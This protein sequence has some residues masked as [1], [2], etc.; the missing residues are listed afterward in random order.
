MDKFIDSYK[1]VYDTVKSARNKN[2][3]ELEK[4]G[5]L[6]SE[7]DQKIIQTFEYRSRKYAEHQLAPK[8]KD[9]HFSLNFQD[10]HDQFNR[11]DRLQFNKFLLE[12]ICENHLN[13]SGLSKKKGLLGGLKKEGRI[14]KGLNDIKSIT[15][16]I[17]KK[18]AP[19]KTVLID[20]DDLNNPEK[21]EE[22]LTQII[23][24]ERARYFEMKNKYLTSGSDLTVFQHTQGKVEKSYPLTEEMYYQIVQSQ[25]ENQKADWEEYDKKHKI[26]RPFELVNDKKPFVFR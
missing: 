6:L 9:L 1:N 21:I 23:L 8:I 13:L 26:D 17:N 16:V 12:T 3:S 22:K 15:P 24:H 14:R 20:S 5:V 4:L 11:P 2:L 18:G 19:V 10:E 7:K 25:K